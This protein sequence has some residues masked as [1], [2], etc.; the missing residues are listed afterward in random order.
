MLRGRV[1]EQNAIDALLAAAERSV[2]GALLLAGEA[3]MGK[4]AL[5]DYA[6]Q[7]AAGFR[8]N[9]VTGIE[10]ES[11][12]AYAGL[13]QLL[14]PW[15]GS[16]AMLRPAQAR[17]L[18]SAVGLDASEQPDRF[19]V[20]A[21]VLEL[22]TEASADAPV[23][24]ALD[25]AQWVDRPSLDAIVFAARRLGAD[26]VAVVAAV[27]DEG[28]GVPAL[29]LPAVRLSGLSPDAVAAMVADLAGVEVPVTVAESLAVQ[30]CGNPLALS[31]LCR[32]LSKDELSGRSSLP[33]PLPPAAGL[34]A[35]FAQRIDSLPAS[36]RTALLVAA[37]AGGESLD[38][39]LTAGDRLGVAVEDLDAPERAGLVVV[40][41]GAILFRHPLVR[42]ASYHSATFAERRAAHLA[43]ADVLAGGE[44][45]ERR[46]W[47][48]ATA[49]VGPDP[50]VAR[51]L[52]HVARRARAR[53][54]YASAAAA[55]ERAAELTDDPRRRVERRL[56]G[57]EAARIAGLFERA[58]AALDASEK[59][60]SDPRS[61]AEIIAA[62]AHIDADHQDAY[63]RAV[64]AFVDAAQTIADVDPWRAAEFLFAA[65]VVAN[66]GGRWEDLDVIAART[67]ALRLPHDTPL[68]RFLIA[69]S[70]TMLGRDDDQS[71]TLASF[72]E[73]DDLRVDEYLAIGMRSYAYLDPRHDGGPDALAFAN[74]ALQRARATHPLD[75]PSLL[76]LVAF[77]E[78]QAGTW[79]A[80]H[81]DAVESL[82]L[83]RDM[84]HK[85]HGATSVLA[86]LAAVQG[87]FDEVDDLV[88][89]ASQ[90]AP[91]PYA[92][93][94]AWARGLGA[95]AAG[96]PDEALG[97]LDLSAYEEGRHEAMMSRW[98]IADLVEAAVQAG[99]H[100]VGERALA[101][102]E[103][104]AESSGSTVVR[105]LVAR[106]R[107]LLAEGET[108]ER[109]LLAAM[110]LH[111][112]HWWPFE[113]ART[114]LALGAHL[115]RAR[116]RSDA[117]DPLRSALREFDRL[118]S[119]PWVD[120]AQAELRATGESSRRRDPTALETLTPQEFQVARFVAEG[121]TNRDVAAQL[122][123]SHR[124]VSYH[125]HNVYR[126]LGIASRTELARVD[127]EGGLDSRA[128]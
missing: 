115:R 111:D 122:F 41:E 118:G 85:S 93:T 48:L 113:R 59:E 99:R 89:P 10:R 72:A 44:D 109:W 73:R 23:L 76:D 42:S 27:R 43:L 77:R 120:R 101:G 96:R 25:D 12:L 68:V 75:V 83:A 110:S 71:E 50:E 36:A 28:D 7:R 106:A 91:G 51:G 62:R 98:Q 38:M 82:A 4:S 63:D 21:A 58:L 17:A 123:L 95:L 31:E 128:R 56:A 11:D 100:D 67:Q 126:K 107:G 114:Q 81:A 121:G 49:A 39:V 40:R 105:A 3:G 74:A 60:A 15:L 57:V 80:A 55:F 13:H 79:P 24:V 78:F 92:V 112:E 2:G 22:L 125:L 46:A 86:L 20:S 103:P 47:H 61:R 116:R 54:A 5:L 29:S 33:D 35:G 37:T 87:R 32:L 104:W 14:R 6:R 52:E 8:V 1:P 64:P 117:R 9:Q 18:S 53:G 16:V 102:Y 66:D 70:N 88:G 19:L 124:T 97:E 34:S 108:A 119:V 127:F 30:T 94:A 45:E 84:R 90:S 65:A 69:A 26:P